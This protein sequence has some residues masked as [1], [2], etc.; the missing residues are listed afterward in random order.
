MNSF[1]I[2]HI[3]LLYI[4]VIAGIAYFSFSLRRALRAFDVWREQMEETICNIKEK[5]GNL[6]ETLPIYYVRNHKYE[7]DIREIKE[8]L[9]K[10]F[11]K[12]DSKMD[13]P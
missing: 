7:K 5:Q 10:I 4:A 3:Y 9:D 13:K 11:D 12:L 2:E 1:W 6:R 8:M